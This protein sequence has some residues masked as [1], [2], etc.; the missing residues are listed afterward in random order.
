MRG[1]RLYVL[2][3]LSAICTL[4]LQGHAYADKRVALVIG[5]SKYV[6]APPL[7]NP[8]NDASDLAATLKEMGFDV[9]LLLDT[10]KPDFERALA[11]FSRRSATAD[12]AWFY[13]AGHGVQRRDRNYLLPTDIEVHDQ[14]D[15]TQLAVKLDA[16][17]EALEESPGVRILILDACR[18]NPFEKLLA[19]RAVAATSAVRGLG[20]IE[21][22]EGML[23]AY[24]AAPN[25]VAMDGSGRNSPFAEALIRRLKEP[26]IEIEAMFKRVRNDVVEKTHG[27]QWPE[28]SSMVR[29][30]FFLTP[31]EDDRSLWS[32][33]KDSDDSAE[34]K[35]FAA[36]FPDS[37]LAH[38]AQFRIQ[39]IERARHELEEQRRDDERIAREKA[40]AQRR[41]AE[42]QEAERLA[43]QKREAERLA[44][45]KAAAARLQEIDRLQVERIAAQRREAERLAAEAS[46]AM[47]R[48][49]DRLEVERLA[50]QKREAE[51]LA[52]ERADADRREAD[53]LEVERL[54]AQ[55]RAARQEPQ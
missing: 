26:G 25:Q 49:A 21:R 24:A 47:S 22:A 16:V 39:F 13:F 3:A 37:P 7:R 45:Q 32:K 8:P 35:K 15:V 46:E 48:Q 34:L 27:A 6:G 19:T 12:V 50:A 41:E 43:Q 55:R 2:L 10:K 51:R 42:R 29:G 36:R 5:N 44:A 14:A 31:P 53:R 11:E 33:L 17:R 20:H 4:A 54:A 38:E 30:D 18:D 9:M 40:D 1:L 23:I 28:V 52:A